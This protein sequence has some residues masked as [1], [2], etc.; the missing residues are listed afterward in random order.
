MT[1]VQMLD[2]G[3]NIH[4]RKLTRK[5]VTA[6]ADYQNAVIGRRGPVSAAILESC[7]VTKVLIFAPGASRLREGL[8]DRRREGSGS[9]NA[10][11]H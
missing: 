3:T 6:R 11:G 8:Y 4:G 7:P 5:Q 9:G 10:F 1:D 2:S